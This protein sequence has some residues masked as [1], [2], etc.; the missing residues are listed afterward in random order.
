MNWPVFGG[1]MYSSPFPGHLVSFLKIVFIQHFCSL[2]KLVSILWWYF[3]NQLFH[4]W[5]AFLH[6]VLIMYWIC[7]SVVVY[8][9][10][11]IALCLLYMSRISVFCSFISDGS[12]VN[13]ISLS[14]SG[15]LCF[16]RDGFVAGQWMLCGIWLVRDVLIDAVRISFILFS[17]IWGSGLD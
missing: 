14:Q 7:S 2:M 5:H 15:D 11:S 9:G 3:Q 12:C 1:I 16:C 8:V 17:L 10:S 6:S 13:L 4:F